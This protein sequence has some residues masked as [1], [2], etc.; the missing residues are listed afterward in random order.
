MER[1]YIVCHMPAFVDGKID[2]N[3]M[4][5]AECRGALMEYGKIREYYECQASLYGTVTMEG[6]YSA[7]LA[8]A[9]L[10]DDVIYPRE[11]Y[12]ADSD[13]KNYI[14]SLDPKGVPKQPSA[15]VW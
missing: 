11:D 5:A 9:D 6:S 13:V 15:G 3:Y 1:P 14:V 10:K 4:S 8:P 7:G 12:V 2:G